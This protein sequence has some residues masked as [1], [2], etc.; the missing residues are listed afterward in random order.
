[1]SEMSEDL[2]NQGIERYQ[3]GESVDT[4]IPHFRQIC[5]RSRRNSPAWTCL[6]WLYLLADK[7]DKAYDAAHKAV[8]FNAEDPQARVNLAI[9]MLETG[10]KGVRSHI[11]FVQQLMSVPEL[12]TEVEQ[13]LADGLNRKPDWSS[14]MRVKSWLFET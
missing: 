1:M 6:A 13:N 14:L 3:A 10:K 2:F 11:E 9:A 8:K 5:A 4:L 7:P 12:R